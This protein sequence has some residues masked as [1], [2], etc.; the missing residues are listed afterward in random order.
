MQVEF[1]SSVSTEWLVEEFGIN[2]EKILGNGVY[3][4]TM[5]SRGEVN[6]IAKISDNNSF[7]LMSVEELI[8]SARAD[9]F[10]EQFDSEEEFLEYCEE[11]FYSGDNSWFST[12]EKTIESYTEQV[13]EELSYDYFWV[14]G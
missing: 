12:D 7:N 9:L 6:E 4:F 1:K 5:E 14:V 11:F 10:V 3:K 2:A 13:S 8:Q